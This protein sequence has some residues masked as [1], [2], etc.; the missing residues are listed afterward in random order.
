MKTLATC[1]T[2]PTAL[3]QRTFP[4]HGT[5]ITWRQDVA[6]NQMAEIMENRLDLFGALDLPQ[7]DSWAEKT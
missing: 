5:T 4:S 1:A 3:N 2:N 7:G 6:M